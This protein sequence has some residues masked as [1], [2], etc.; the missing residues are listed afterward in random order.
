MGGVIFAALGR[1]P[2]IGVILGYASASGGFTAN[3]F[4]AGTDALLAG[5]TESIVNEMGLSVPINPA[6]N[7]FFM[8]AATFILSVT[9]TL[10][11]EKL[12][13]VWWAMGT[14]H[15]MRASLKSIA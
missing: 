13:V 11:T 15:L 6:V 1:N 8:A 7:Y 12:F 14:G 4:L 2:L 3:L 9:M 5:I 10:F